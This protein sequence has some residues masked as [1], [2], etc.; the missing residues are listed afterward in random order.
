[1]SI[2]ALATVLDFAPEHWTTGTRMVAVALADHVNHDGQA[3]PA[4]D[5]LARRAG[6][7]PR[8]AQYHLRQLEADGWITR[9]PRLVDGRQR[10]NLWTWRM[11]ITIPGV[12]HTSPQGW[13]V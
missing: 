3:W 11:W 13:H 7:S 12:Q 5:T 2:R 4:I 9:T 6:V 1:M 10:A 8:M